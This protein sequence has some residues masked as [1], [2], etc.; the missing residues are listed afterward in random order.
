[1]KKLF[2]LTALLLLTNFLFAAAKD[3]NL[4]AVVDEN[5][6]VIDFVFISKVGIMAL[7][8]IIAFISYLKFRKTN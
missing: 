5:P 6:K 4:A 2:V 3:Q 1:M 7:L 8:G